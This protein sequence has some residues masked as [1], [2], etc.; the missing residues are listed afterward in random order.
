MIKWL[1]VGVIL[2]FGLISLVFFRIYFRTGMKG[3]FLIGLA[4]I[5]GIIGLSFY[6]KPRICYF[7]L[8]IAL[9]LNYIAM[10]IL[11]TIESGGEEMIRKTSFLSRITGRVPI[12]QEN[13][14]KLIIDRKKGIMWGSI[15]IVTGIIYY[16][17]Y[18]SNHSWIIYFLGTITIII[19]IGILIYNI[20]SKKNKGGE[21]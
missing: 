12:I 1:I 4:C 7:F 20:Y 6:S 21:N 10:F 2:F 5:I 18:F 13:K 11:S 15:V 8:A 19:G 9:I 17:S 14:I 16:F 3:Q